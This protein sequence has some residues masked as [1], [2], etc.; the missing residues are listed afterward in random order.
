M[1]VSLAKSQL[2]GNRKPPFITRKTQGVGVVLRLFLSWQEGWGWFGWRVTSIIC[3]LLSHGS[4]GGHQ[5]QSL[6]CEPLHLDLHTQRPYNYTR[7]REELPFAGGSPLP[8]SSLRKG[9]PHPRPAYS[10]SA[11]LVL[12]PS[13]WMTQSKPPFLSASY[14][15]CCQ[16]RS[17]QTPDQNAT[18]LLKPSNGSHCWQNK[19]HT[20][21]SRSGPAPIIQ[22]H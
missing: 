13:T 22:L 18:V 6:P 1:L 15:R 3:P 20:G 14:H 16:T 19:T 17:F 9:I 10:F 21:P 2:S 8:G 7:G 4:P 12:S 11:L 5:F